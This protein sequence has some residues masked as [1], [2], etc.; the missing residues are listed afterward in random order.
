MDRYVDSMLQGTAR[1][2][3][4]AHRGGAASACDTHRLEQVGGVAARADRNHHIACI[5]EARELLSEDHLIA[6]VI[7]PGREQSH[8]VV[9]E[10]TRTRRCPSMMVAL[11]RSQAK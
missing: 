8:V 2:A 3:D 4:Q 9:S 1:E 5:Q 7:R 10:V 6:R 11:D